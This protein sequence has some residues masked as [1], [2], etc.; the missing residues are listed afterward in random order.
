MSDGEQKIVQ[1]TV[2]INLKQVMIILVSQWLSKRI[3]E[4]LVAQSR[5]NRNTSYWN[6]GLIDPAESG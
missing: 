2:Q 5:Q 3:R 1:V 6:A 4:L